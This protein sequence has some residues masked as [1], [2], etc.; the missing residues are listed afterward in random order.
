MK[1]ELRAVWHW[2]IG[3]MSDALP[4]L[5]TARK[6]AAIIAFAEDRWVH[7]KGREQPNPDIATISLDATR[8]E[9][10]ITRARLAGVARLNSLVVLRLAPELGMR[11]QTV[12]PAAA[13]EHLDTIV[14]NELDRLSPWRPDQAVHVARILSRTE[15][16]DL[17]T[18]I[19]VVPRFV[20]AE[21]AQNLQN[22]G[23]T[24]AGLL[25]A[26]PDH[27]PDFIPVEPDIAAAGV[28]ERQRARQFGVLICLLLLI[29]FIG[30][31]ARLW[32]V[33][34]LRQESAALAQGA[35]HVQQMVDELAQLSDR[36]YYA[37]TAKN[38]QPAA[39]VTWEALSEILPDDCWLDRLTLTGNQVTIEGHASDALALLPLL[40][41]SGRF[42]EVHF[43]SEVTR[44]AEAGIEGF[45]ITATVVQDAEL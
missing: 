33:H 45:S 19:I 2:W 29:V 17:N 43:D 38:A 16:G 9:Q 8:A 39:I 23:L 34:E 10:Q 36:T 3:Q 25:L 20:F 7:L 37:V 14:A 30:F 12:M 44:D 26:H 27:G 22:V 21:I 28:L 42:A 31:G 6:R 24:L 32:S 15:A 35:A 4:T 18:E 40:T 41:S 13:E 11:R 1:A 5:S